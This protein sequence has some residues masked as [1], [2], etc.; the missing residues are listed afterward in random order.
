VTQQQLGLII[1]MAQQ[2]V[3]Q[4]ELG[5]ANITLE[6][7]VRLALAVDRNLGFLLGLSG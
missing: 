4:V 7:M 2:N 1:G 5:K 3:A 6:T